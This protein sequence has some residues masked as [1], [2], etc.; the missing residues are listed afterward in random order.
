MFEVDQ[1]T[2]RDVLFAFMVNLV[3]PFRKGRG[4]EWGQGNK[5][6]RALLGVGVGSIGGIGN[7]NG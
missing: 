5:G 2:A 6:V 3:L 4:G 1:I 7:V